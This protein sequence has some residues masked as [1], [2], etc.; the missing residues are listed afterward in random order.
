[1]GRQAGDQGRYTSAERRDL[2]LRQALG[3]LVLLVI[4]T[5][6]LIALVRRNPLPAAAARGFDSATLE[7]SDST[8]MPTAIPILSPGGTLRIVWRPGDEA[9]ATHGGVVCVTADGPGHVCVAYE[10]GDRA[11]EL[12]TREVERRGYRVQSID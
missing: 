2:R 12:L 5:G 10:V 11:A 6:F 3:L 9:P 4:G 1:M 8:D 7:P